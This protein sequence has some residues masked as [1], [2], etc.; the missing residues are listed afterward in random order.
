MI[1]AD[2]FMYVVYKNR[3]SFLKNKLALT[4]IILGVF[5]FVG[6]V[7]IP[8]LFFSLVVT[9]TSKL[10]NT[11]INGTIVR[12]L[13]N[14]T[15]ASCKGDFVPTISSDL[16]SITIRTYIPFALMLAFNTIMI[17]KIV[18]NARSFK[19]SSLSKKEYQFTLTVMSFDVLFFIAN[20]P[21]SVF[22]IIDDINK[23][24]GSNVY[25]IYL[26]YSAQMSFIGGIASYFTYIEQCSSFFM[27]MAFN[28]LFRREFIGLVCFW[29]AGNRVFA[30]ENTM[31]L[32]HTVAGNHQQLKNRSAT[33]G[34]K[35]H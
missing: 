21:L 11:T 29:R 3:F 24:S 33:I 18:G 13:T 4:A 32:T 34:Q 30:G 14:T 2:R 1:T 31:T 10:T 27:Y 22:Y 8:N 26:V 28:K 9:T 16:I 6:I 23:Y 15:S 17:K 25:T 19:Q 20:F 7:D 35:S 12:V 5:T